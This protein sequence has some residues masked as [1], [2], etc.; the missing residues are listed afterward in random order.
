MVQAWWLISDLELTVVIGLRVFMR[1]LAYLALD[2][3]FA[4]RFKLLT[5]DSERSV[6]H[7]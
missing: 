6:R 1:L 3:D 7:K 2:R 4:G 5:V